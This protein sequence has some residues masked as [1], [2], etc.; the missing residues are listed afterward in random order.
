MWWIRS[1][2]TSPS[3]HPPGVTFPFL[4]RIRCSST[5]VF[6]VFGLL[7][8]DEVVVT[9]SHDL[10]PKNIV[11][12]A[13]CPIA[14]VKSSSFLSNSF[15]RLKGRQ[16][17]CRLF[18]SLYFYPHMTMGIELNLLLLEYR[19]GSLLKLS[20][21]VFATSPIVDLTVPVSKVELVVLSCSLHLI[22]CAKS[23]FNSLFWHMLNLVRKE[24]FSMP[25]FLRNLMNI[26]NWTSCLE[27]MDDARDVSLVTSTA[28]TESMIFIL[29]VVPI[30]LNSLES[31]FL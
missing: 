2:P 1:M 13:S 25:Y 7:S 11:P 10:I 12:L 27:C 23:T 29:L 14:F 22:E 4:Y 26:L 20:L 19:V 5:W 24:S 6:F 8:S 17:Q 21:K 18:G 31:I 3:V 16:S 15:K 9:Y 28:V 30:F